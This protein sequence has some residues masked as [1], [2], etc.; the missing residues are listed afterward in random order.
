MET[1]VD[2]IIE[3]LDHQGNRL[4]SIEADLRYHVKRTDDLQALA[5]EFKRY[6]WM[7]MGAIIVLGPIATKLIQVVFK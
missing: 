1:K 5:E 2:K 6:K 3:K 4:T 7:V